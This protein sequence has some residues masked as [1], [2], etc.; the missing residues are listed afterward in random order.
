MRVGRWEALGAILC[1]VVT[2]AGLV[3]LL[4]F[5]ARAQSSPGQQAE[6]ASFPRK[7]LEEISYT[8]WPTAVP[9]ATPIPWP[10]PEPPPPPPE[11]PPAEAPPPPP[12]APVP[13]VPPPPPPAVDG[14]FSAQ[15]FAQVNAERVAR[16]LAPVSESASLSAESTRFAQVQLDLNTLSH[17]AD[18][19]TLGDRGASAGY[20]NAY[21]G[22]VLWGGHGTFDPQDPVIGWLNSPDHRDVILGGQFTVAGVGCVFREGGDYDDVRCVMMFVG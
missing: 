12:P 21:L 1:V 8:L 11:P 13:Y 6:F 16:G 9:T 17:K 18:G 20:V 2:A 15:V 10:T 4:T 3:G 7:N 14:S 19:T 22:E 5:Q